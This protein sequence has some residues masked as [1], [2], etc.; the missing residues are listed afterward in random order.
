MVLRTLLAV[1]LLVAAP[2]MS[3]TAASAAPAPRTGPV[4]LACNGYVALTYDDGPNAQ[5]TRPLISALRS[6]GARATFFDLGSR[7]QQQPQLTRETAQAGMWVGNHSWSHPYLTNLSAAAVAKEL[8]D[9]Q[10]AIRNAT[11]QTPTLFRPPYG[12]TNSTVQTE[13][14]RLGLTQVTWSVDTQDWN[15]A[16]TDA[17]VRAATGANA[18]GIV[19][20]HASYQNTVN[21]VPRI[22]QGL[23]AKNLCP[24]RIDNTGRVVAP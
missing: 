2:L 20:M 17:I 8:G 19:L 7:V 10:N 13:A 15:G 22:V 9:T 5:F 14:R 18:G 16:S 4:A 21:A 1:V 11:G 3:S 12:A 23:A 24:G 6:A